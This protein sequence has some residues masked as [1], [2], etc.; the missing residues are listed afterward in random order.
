MS[1][2]ELMMS[3]PDYTTLRIPVNEL[4]HVIGPTNASV[5]VVN[6]GDYECGDCHER[7]R[8]IQK[9]IDQLTSSVRF[10]YRHFPL[11]KVHPNALRAAEA[12]E[13]AA[14]Q[15][16]FWEMHQR[17]YTHPEKLG[18]RE[19]RRHAHEIGLDLDRFDRE[20]ASS[21]YADRVLKDYYNSINNGITGA[22]TTFINGVLYSMSGVELLATV[23]SLL[24]SGK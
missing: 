15:N 9:V 13:A 1:F 7:H 6:Y 23:K 24:A 14:A 5:V 3:E 2:E 4:D 17:L 12:A 21:S 18:N 22:P 20:M 16:K 8:A 19:F 10:V 11:V